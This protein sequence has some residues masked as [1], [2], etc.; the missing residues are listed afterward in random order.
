ME[1]SD[2]FLARL[3]KF[4]TEPAKCSEPIPPDFDDDDLA[5]KTMMIRRIQQLVC[6]EFKIDMR[7]LLSPS[8]KVSYVIARQAGYYLARHLTILSM[9]A[10]GRKFHRDHTSILHGIRV[11]THR[12]VTDKA[13]A[14]SIQRIREQ[15]R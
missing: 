9:P 2:P 7:D 3:A 1:R 4:H 13:L 12:I 5:P 15:C 10:I 8:R 11:T 14:R 6:R